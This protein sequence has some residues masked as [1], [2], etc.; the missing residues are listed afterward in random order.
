MV[1]TIQQETHELSL[2]RLLEFRRT[3]RVQ[4]GPGIGAGK[5]PV[6]TDTGTVVLLF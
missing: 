5:G 6:V 2:S 4:T 1:S 3:S